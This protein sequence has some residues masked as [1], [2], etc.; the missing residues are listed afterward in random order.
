GRADLGQH[1]RVELRA[2]LLD[3]VDQVSVVVRRVGAVDAYDDGGLE[4]ER[5]ERLYYARASG[6]L[7]VRRDGVLE[8]KEYLVGL[9][10]RRLRK[11]ALARSGDGVAR[12]SRPHG[13][14]S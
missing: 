14:A 1:D 2:R 3:H 6:V 11:E 10:F 5:V 4:R 13:G 12:S 9:E 7:L 8:V